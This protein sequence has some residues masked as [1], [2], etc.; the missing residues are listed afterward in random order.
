MARQ[1]SPSFTQRIGGNRA[2]V[3]VIMIVM[4]VLFTVDLYVLPALGVSSRSGDFVIFTVNGRRVSVTREKFTAS[5]AEWQKFVQGITGGRIGGAGM[6]A[7]IELLMLEE[8][9]RDAGIAIPDETLSE[10]LR[11][12]EA[13]QGSGGEFDPKVFEEVLGRAFGGMS[14]RSYEEEA[15]RYLLLNH[16]RSL[17]LNASTA[18]SEE[19]CWRKWKGEH[20]RLAVAY[21]WQPTGPIREGMKVA[22]LK[23]EEVEAFWKDPGVQGRHKIPPKRAFE[24]AWIRVDDVTD[25]AF[26]AAREATKDDPALAV[27]EDEAHAFWWA[28]QKY[29]FTLEDRDP[30]ILEALRKSNESPRKEEPPK[31]EEAPKEPA[32]APG[33]AKEEAPAVPAT[34]PWELDVGEQFRLYWRH[35]IEKEVWLR[36]L[37]DRVREEAKDGK[38]PLADAAAKW[39]RPGVE[40]RFHRQETPLDQYEVEK[41]EGPGGATLRYALNTYEKPGEEGTLHPDTMQRTALTNRLDQRGWVVAR[42]AGIRPEAVPPLADVREKVAAELLDDRAKEQA[43]ARLEGLRKA[44]EEGKAALEEAAKKEGIECAT[45]DP[46]NEYSWRPPLSRPAPGETGPPPADGWKD[47]ARRLS[48]LMGKY[49]PMREVP[50]GAFSDVFDDVAATGAFYLAQVKSR[51]EP[52]FEEMTQAHLSQ[53]RRVLAR[54]RRMALEAELSYGRL[55]D[56]LGL[57]LDGKPA[58]EPEEER[59][60]RR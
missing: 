41:L 59:R 32:P 20:P 46:F 43:R 37:L 19:E 45:T 13:F 42:V 48:A 38:V 26:D 10:F 51:T 1:A 31:K 11:H 30:A 12:Q 36:K 21:A 29:D 15:R 55:K 47:P 9:A 40:I 25:A 4:L 49:Y 56:R 3:L 60:G 23:D 44:A 58:P 18:V 50:V 16:F 14:A 8:L 52:R 6:E 7:Y 34:D 35:R 28:S 53:V 57:L 24:A 27:K 33:E 39:S 17:Y 22:D 2:I 5:M 54:E